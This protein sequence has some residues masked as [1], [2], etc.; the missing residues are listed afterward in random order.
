MDDATLIG[1]ASIIVA[2][3]TISL[4][5]VG[6]ALA[7]GHIVFTGATGIAI[8]FDANVGIGLFSQKIAIGFDPRY[9][10]RANVR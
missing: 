4:G 6:P 9:L 10:V 3:L 8:A 2:G 7:Q 1:T 5:S